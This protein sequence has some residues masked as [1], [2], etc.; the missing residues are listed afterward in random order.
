MSEKTTKQSFLNFIFKET[1]SSGSFWP[2]EW[3]GKRHPDVPPAAAVTIR[4]EETG[5]AGRALSLGGGH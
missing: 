4:L 3:E 2:R 1:V 5:R